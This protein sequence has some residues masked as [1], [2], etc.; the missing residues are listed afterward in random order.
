MLLTKIGFVHSHFPIF[1]TDTL[2]FVLGPNSGYYTACTELLKNY[3]T[4]SFPQF[5]DL[6]FFIPLY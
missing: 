3:F 4:C 5:S 6:L 2:F 1:P